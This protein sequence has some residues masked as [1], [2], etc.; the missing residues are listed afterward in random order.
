LAQG[1]LEGR[2]GFSL[3]SSGPT[4]VALTHYS[5]IKGEIRSCFINRKK[6]ELKS[7]MAIG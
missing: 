7:I 6:A 3:P 4:K 5:S 1:S 2:G